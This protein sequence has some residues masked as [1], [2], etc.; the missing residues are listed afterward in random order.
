MKKSFIT[1]GPGHFVCIAMKGR[2]LCTT[3]SSDRILVHVALLDQMQVT[4]SLQQL[5]VEHRLIC[6]EFLI[7]RST[8]SDL[9]KCEHYYDLLQEV[10]IVELGTKRISTK[11]RHL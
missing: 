10:T 3:A 5:K 8:F 11:S 4:D 7:L 9:V 1:S 2:F 6:E